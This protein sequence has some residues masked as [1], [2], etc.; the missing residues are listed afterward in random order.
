MCHVG[1]EGFFLF[2]RVHGV[3]VYASR[4]ARH[5]WGDC[6]YVSKTF[7]EC[8]IGGGISVVGATEAVT[9]N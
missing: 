6:C 1:R 8:F 4:L 3:F 7:S 2:V 5:G 9:D